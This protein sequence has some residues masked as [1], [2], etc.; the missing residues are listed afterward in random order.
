M[1]RPFVLPQPERGW[2]RTTAAAMAEGM[3]AVSGISS[4]EIQSHLCLRSSGGAPVAGGRPHPVRNTGNWDPRGEQSGRFSVG[5]LAALLWGPCQSRVTVHPPGP[6]G[7]T[8]EGWR[9]AKT[10]ACLSLPRR[11]P[12]QGGTELLPAESPGG[13]RMEPQ[14]VEPHPVRCSGGKAGGQCLL[15]PVDSAPFLGVCKGA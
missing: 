5:Q 15:S 2:G 7:K 4:R 6:E 11:A 8:G 10:V 9:T 1:T 14:A 3:W 12:S 13:E